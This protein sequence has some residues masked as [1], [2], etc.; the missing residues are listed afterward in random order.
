M[1]SVLVSHVQIGLVIVTHVEDRNVDSAIVLDGY[2]TCSTVHKD[3][4][5]LFV[6]LDI[7]SFLTLVLLVCVLQWGLC[8]FL[9]NSLSSLEDSLIKFICK[10]ALHSFWDYISQNTGKFFGERVG[11]QSSCISVAVMTMRLAPY[12][13]FK[14]T[15]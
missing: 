6:I 1:L 13:H 3:F 11:K 4:P 15:P 8:A 12:R 7:M 9:A 5:D 14:L 2:G 10:H